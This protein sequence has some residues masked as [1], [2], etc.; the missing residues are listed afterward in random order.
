MVLQINMKRNLSTLLK[1]W[2]KSDNRKPLIIQ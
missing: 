2:K 1:K